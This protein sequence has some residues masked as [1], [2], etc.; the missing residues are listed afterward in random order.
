[1]K[2][3]KLS[4]LI[5]DLRN[6]SKSDLLSIS[7]NFRIISKIHLMNFSSNVFFVIS[8]VTALVIGL[9]LNILFILFHNQRDYLY[10]ILVILSVV[11]IFLIVTLLFMAKKYYKSSNHLDKVADDILEKYFSIK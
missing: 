6:A 2:K 4:P 9:I 5:V 11:L 7:N 8:I 1:M 3:K 10:L